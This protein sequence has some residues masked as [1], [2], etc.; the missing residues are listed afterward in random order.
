MDQNFCLDYITFCSELIFSK[1][2]SW[3]KTRIEFINR[4][5]ASYWIAA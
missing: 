4:N 3:T 5:P 1:G 2:Y